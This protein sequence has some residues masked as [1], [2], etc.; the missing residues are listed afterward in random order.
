MPN[1]HENVLTRQQNVLIGR[2]LHQLVLVRADSRCSARR[3]RRLRPYEGS[4]PRRA[5]GHRRDD[6]GSVWLLPG[7]IS[8]VST[9]PDGIQLALAPAEFSYSGMGRLKVAPVAVP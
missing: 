9:D 6:P 2:I 3:K 1:S 7:A 5:P 4:A 8:G